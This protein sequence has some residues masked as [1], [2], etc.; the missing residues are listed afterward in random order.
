MR[1]RNTQQKKVIM[2][3][4]RQ[5]HSHPTAE[6]VYAEVRQTLPR[7]SLG[8]VYRNL[9]LL[10]SSGAIRKIESPGASRRFDGDLNPHHHARCLS[11]GRV[12]DLDGPPPRVSVEKTPGGF[13]VSGYRIELLGT[14]ERCSLSAGAPAI[15]SDWIPV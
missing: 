13:Q 4:L 3:F 9:E 15:K 2:D 1:H 14:C 7:I 11:C 6:E 10:A 5:S 8:T 12:K